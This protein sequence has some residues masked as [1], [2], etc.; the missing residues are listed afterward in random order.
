MAIRFGSADHGSYQCQLEWLTI[1][2]RGCFGQ[3]PRI[4]IREVSRPCHWCACRCL[5]LLPV[6]IGLERQ[7]PGCSGTAITRH[8]LHFFAP[9]HQSQ[10]ATNHGAA[11]EPPHPHAIELLF[12]RAASLAHGVGRIGS[13]ELFK[14]VLCVEHGVSLQ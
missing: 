9:E 1:R 4:H 3:K 10:Q 2:G 12:G 14:K 5:A 7:C 6:L 8:L 11:A 13:E